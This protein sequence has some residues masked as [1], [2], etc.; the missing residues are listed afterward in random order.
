MSS[1]KQVYENKK[2]TLIG[3]ERLFLFIDETGD[4]GHPDQRDASTYYQLN[5]TLANR[6]GVGRIT[7]HFSR[8]RY[9][10]DADKELERYQRSTKKLHEILSICA[11]APE[12]RFYS[13]CLNKKTY[14]GPYL[15]KIDKGKF[16]YNPGKFRNFIIRKSL[17]ALFT[18]EITDSFVTPR[19]YELVFD[20]F[21]SSEE[22]EQ[23]LRNYLRGNFKLPPF[24]HILQ[25]DSQYSDQI[26]VTDFMGKMVKDYVFGSVH[27]NELDFVTIYH[28]DN[29]EDVVNR[30]KSGHP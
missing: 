11:V 29:P 6:S 5:I 1:V 12:V 24:L 3:G 18:Y 2:T 23:E 30:K 22:D 8:F 25:I 17:E 10:L 7:R 20:R 16:D 15:K 27:K 21:L 14:I 13:F 9:F 28:L 26:Q 4:P 19:E